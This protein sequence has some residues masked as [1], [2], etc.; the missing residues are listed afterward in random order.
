M[1]NIECFKFLENYI[2][3]FEVIFRKKKIFK[4]C[5]IKVKLVII[6][7]FCILWFK[8]V[9]LG[10]YFEVEKYL[11]IKLLKLVMFLI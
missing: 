9:I 7:K 3:N 2:W 6:G 5:W 8:Y 4:N 11:Y 1:R 10:K